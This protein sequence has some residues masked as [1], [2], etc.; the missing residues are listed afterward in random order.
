MKKPLITFF[1]VFA[2][3]FGI[4]AAINIKKIETNV[5]I[6]KAPAFVVAKP[7]GIIKRTKKSRDTYQVKFSYSIA[8]INYN[9][10]SDWF[11]TVAEAEALAKSPVQIAYDSIKPENA[12]FRSDF[13]KRDPNEVTISALIS[14][15]GL[16]LF[17]ALLLT[18][19][20]LYKFP[21]LRRS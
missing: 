7:D 11:D 20:L 15:G 13:D 16:G 14:A 3:A 21:S 4:M 12:V 5:A 8:G 17:M 10:D 9:M 2:I 18:A 1:V 6:A 19:V